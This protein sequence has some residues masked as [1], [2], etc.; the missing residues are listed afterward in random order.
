MKGRGGCEDRRATVFSMQLK[1]SHFNVVRKGK[2]SHVCLNVLSKS[3]IALDPEHARIFEAGDVAA[4]SDSEQQML[5]EQGILVDSAID[6]LAVVRRKYQL[7]KESTGQLDLVIAPTMRCN[8]SCKYCFETPSNCDADGALMA[9]LLEFVDEQL[10]EHNYGKVK[11]SWYG[12]EPLLALSFLVESASRLVECCLKRDC[13]I[14]QGIVTNG[15]LLDANT[16]GELVSAGIHHAQ[17][18][19]DG[20]EEMHDARRPLKNGCGSY[21]RII[22]NLKEISNHYS[23]NDFDLAIRF[24]SDR[25]NEGQFEK[26]VSLFAS[27]DENMFN[28]YPAMVEVVETH[29]DSQASC[30]TDE[31]YGE[32]RLAQLKGLSITE[33]MD[34][35]LQPRACFCTAEKTHAYVID[36]RGNVFNCW[37][38]ICF[39]DH[40][41]FNL[42]EDRVDSPRAISWYLGRDPFSEAECS[43]CPYIPIC[44][45]GCSYEKRITGK[46]RCV[47]EKYCIEKLLSRYEA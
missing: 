22:S 31:E 21:R 20:T 23:S 16:V 2:N 24:N 46:N 4:L 32:F 45:G 26:V 15:F 29:I 37:N 36:P 1:F 41:L 47:P 40:R 3:I 19:I 8:F 33:S 27:L 34:D 13:V 5:A 30:F 25:E 38:D 17:V 14:E 18:T 42:F 35:L 39:P 43:S 11:V 28:V 44:V 10:C 6:E 7:G 9:K 12:G